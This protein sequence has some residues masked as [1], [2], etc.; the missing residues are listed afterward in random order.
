MLFNQFQDDFNLLHI[1][2]SYLEPKMNGNVLLMKNSDFTA[3]KFIKIYTSLTNKNTTIVFV[4]T[5]CIFS[6]QRP[7]WDF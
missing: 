3:L 5:F 6:M 1:E 4:Q 2:K 7:G